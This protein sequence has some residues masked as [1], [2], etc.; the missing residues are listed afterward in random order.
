M[1]F[2]IPSESVCTDPNCNCNSECP[3]NEPPALIK[4]P[5]I[6][7]TCTGCIYKWEEGLCPEN[8]R[9]VCKTEKVIFQKAKVKK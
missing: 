4:R 2:K 9:Y 3:C 8:A 7:G 6:N 5:Q 1:T